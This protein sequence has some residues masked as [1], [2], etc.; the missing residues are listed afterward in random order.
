M[1]KGDKIFIAGH[2]G[3]VGSAIKRRLTKEGFVNLIVRSHKELDL[4]KQNEVSQYFTKEKPVYVFVAAATVGGIQANN[5]YRGQFLYENLMIQSNIIHA[6]HQNGV[7]KLMFLGS[8]CIYPRNS[9]QPI[10]E[11]YL[12]SG[13]LESTNEPYAIAK[14]AGI[15]MCE[16]YFKQY[17]DNNI[18]VMPSNLYGPNDNYDLETSHV[19]PALMRKFHEAKI[20]NEKSVEIWGSGKPKR[21]FLHVDDLADACIFLMINLD[22]DKLYSENISHINI[23][24]GEEV[25]INELA[26][27]IKDIVG[28]EGELVFN[29]NYPDGMPRK[30]LNIDKINNL[31]WESSISLKDGIRDTYNW[32]INN[33]T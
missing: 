15:K 31:G 30:L 24:C 11:E 25:S 27:L 8:A 19:L 32:F 1:N 10:R 26:L 22:A 4:I 13:Y 21:E 6:A 9:K 20:N 33:Y 2:S 3:M 17:G 23:G 7:K 29:T 5:T 16:N 12:L 28:F 18:S 14:I